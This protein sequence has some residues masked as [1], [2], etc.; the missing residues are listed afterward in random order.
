MTKKY[1]SIRYKIFFIL[2]S[3]SLLSILSVGGTAI[4]SMLKMKHSTIEIMTDKSEDMLKL[5]AQKQGE[6]TQEIIERTEQSISILA[7]SIDW[8]EES[9]NPPRRVMGVGKR[10]V[11]LKRVLNSMKQN[12]PYIYNSYVTSTK[13]E[14][15]FFSR[16]KTLRE[17]LVQNRYDPLERPW[18]KKARLNPDSLVWSDVYMGQSSKKLMITCSKVIRN[19]QNKVVAVVGIDLTIDDM[20]KQVINTQFE[21]SGYA[22]LIDSKGKLLS[23]P[24][25]PKNDLR[26]DAIATVPVGE[27]MK[28]YIKDT[29]FHKILDTMIKDTSGFLQWDQTNG[30]SKYIAFQTASDRNWTLGLVISKSDLEN[31]VR[32]SV[33]HIMKIVLGFFI[34][35]I[36]IIFLINILIGINASKNITK[37]IKQLNDG[38]Q[39]IGAGNLEHTIEVKTG[40]ELEHL[41]EEFN[42]MS[43]DL[44]QYI[45]DLETTTK[46]KERMESELSI[47]SRIQQDMLPLIFPPFPDRDDIELY[48]SMKAAKQVGGDFY[49]FFLI[50]P[51]KLCFVIADVSGKGIPASLFMVISK[52]LMKSEAQ[53]N[54]SCADVLER[55]NNSLNEG[56]DEMM[57]VTVLLCMLDLST[58]EL[59]FAN[60]GHN[61]PLL[62]KK[63]GGVSYMELNKAKI[64]GVFPDR[65]YTNQTLNLEPGDTLFLYTDGV[66]EAMNPDNE[67]FTEPRLLESL[68][69]LQGLS[70][71]EIEAGVQ[72]DVKAF[73]NGAEQSDDITM[74]VVRYTGKEVS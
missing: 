32:D 74:L 31:E 22:F 18:Y 4:Y 13:G 47:A 73:V 37:P 48:A 63:G 14:L 51:T 60:G 6:I 66:T 57:F 45:Q 11:E 52:T 9:E 23:R 71:D 44:K 41:A 3:I 68:K 62:M 38:A 56:N 43:T 35:I 59:Q 21:E 25:I 16:D 49:D 5:M 12:N 1:T 19:S 65:K 33:S 61:P 67:Q 2:I 70:V 10:D 34:L 40:D 55:V 54:L 7:E 42:A 58:G 72:K 64:L 28:V 26:W 8:E 30:E 29:A 46:L 20:N 39:E 50:S 53:G 15:Q 69:K 36:I 27:S 17:K 24:D